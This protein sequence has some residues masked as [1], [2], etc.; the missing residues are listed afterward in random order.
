MLAE[1]FAVMV[2]ERGAER[3][4]DWLEQAES[5]G[6]A[7]LKSFAGGIRRDYGAVKAGLSVAYSNGVVEGHVNRLKCVKRQM[8]GR[9]NFDL[10]RKRVVY[11]A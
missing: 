6:V 2:R 8:F 9:A 4:D 1:E 3:L 11:A 5:S 7:A 10:L